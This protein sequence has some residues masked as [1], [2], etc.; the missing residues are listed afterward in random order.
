MPSHTLRSYILSRL[1][2]LF[3]DVISRI[4]S[5]D[6]FGRANKRSDQWNRKGFLVRHCR[7]QSRIY[8]QQRLAQRL[9]CAPKL[10]RL[11]D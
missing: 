8:L 7:L 10:G 2:D 1:L 5:F 9:Y 11:F 6:A 3:R 4:P